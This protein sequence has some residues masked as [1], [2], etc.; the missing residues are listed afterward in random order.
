MKFL[1]ESGWDESCWRQY[2]TFLA[3]MVILTLSVPGLLHT[4]KDNAG[5]QSPCVHVDIS[6]DIGCIRK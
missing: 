2:N 6:T 1:P 4:V 5:L 3:R